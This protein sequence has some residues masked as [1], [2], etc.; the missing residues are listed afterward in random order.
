MFILRIAFRVRGELAF[1]VLFLLIPNALLIPA[2]EDCGTLELRSLPDN[3][4]ERCRP[5]SIGPAEIESAVSL[6]PD[7]GEVRDL[8]WAQRGKLTA[9]IRVFA[10]HHR[11]KTYQ[12][13]VIDLPIATTAL[14]GRAVLLITL[15]AL[16]LLSEVELQALAAHEIGHEY[17]WSDWAS[18]KQRR[19][20]AR[21]R[22]LELICDT[23]A[24]ETLRELG[25]STDA[26]GSAIKRVFYYNRKLFGVAQNEHEYPTIA[27]RLAVVDRINDSNGAQRKR[28]EEEPAGSRGCESPHRKGVANHRDIESCAGSRAAPSSPDQLR[29]L[30]YRLATPASSRNWSRATPGGFE[31]PQDRL[32]KATV[33]LPACPE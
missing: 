19:D 24:I 1:R 23:V 31:R 2:A 28:R 27:E 12:V 5:V 11:E 25:I 26:L 14:Y 33:P 10:V 16:D 13:K 30:G 7:S 15:P 20:F 22:E 4:F 3:Y 21:A 29:T 6:L 17:T 18:V 8:T 32:P 9:L